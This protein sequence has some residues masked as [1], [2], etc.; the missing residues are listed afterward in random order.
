MKS[1]L[2]SVSVLRCLLTCSIY[3]VYYN[4]VSIC[5]IV[6]SASSS[7]EGVRCED[8]VNGQRLYTSTSL[9]KISSYSSCAIRDED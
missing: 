3:A 9:K 1:F 4:I 5:Y 7:G 8:L 2:D 6:S